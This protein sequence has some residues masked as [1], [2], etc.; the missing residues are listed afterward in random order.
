MPIITVII[1]VK[2]YFSCLLKI[3]NKNKPSHCFHSINRRKNVSVFKN[4]PITLLV[5][6]GVQA[7]YIKIPVCHIMT[8]NRNYVS[9]HILPA[10]N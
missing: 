6:R 7:V 2:S 5:R 8:L 3:Q 1:V 4:I 10:S 9:H